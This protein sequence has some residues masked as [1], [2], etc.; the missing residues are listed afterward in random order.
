MSYNGE[1]EGE[2]L[3]NGD[4]VWEVSYNGGLEGKGDI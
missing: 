1:L 4:Q 3:Y 2:V